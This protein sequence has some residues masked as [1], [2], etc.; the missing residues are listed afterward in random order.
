MGLIE[1]LTGG[2]NNDSGDGNNNSNTYSIYVQFD[3]DEPLVLKTN[4]DI[5]KP[6]VLQ[7][8]NKENSFIEIS[9]PKTNKTVKIFTQN[10]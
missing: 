3:E 5:S 9:C 7:L 2:L 6:F 1:D 4:I 8:D 10:D